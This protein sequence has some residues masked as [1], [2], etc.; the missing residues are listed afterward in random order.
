MDKLATDD[1]TQM[2]YY[3]QEGY[4]SQ[5]RQPYADLGEIVT[6]KKPG[7]E[8]PEE[9]TMSLNLGLALEDMAVAILIYKEAVR[10]GV[11]LRLP[12]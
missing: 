8:T 1:L 3:Q 2:V 4:F 5:I 6:G 10:L 9:R 12:L 7:R 11:G